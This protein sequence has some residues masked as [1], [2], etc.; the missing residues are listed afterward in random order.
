[1]ASQLGQIAAWNDDPE[2]ASLPVGDKQSVLNNYFDQNLADKEFYQL[3]RGEQDK[4]KRSFIDAQYPQAEP[5]PMGQGP[6]R[7]SPEAALGRQQ[8]A[9]V[10]PQQIEQPGNGDGQQQQPEPGPREMVGQYVQDT[11]ANDPFLSEIDSLV[12]DGFAAPETTGVAG[13][14][15]PEPVQ[16]EQQVMGAS[17]VPT[18]FLERAGQEFKGGIQDVQLDIQGFDI[19]M[20]RAAGMDT[21]AE[22]QG[23]LEARKARGEQAVEETDDGWLKKAALGAVRMSGPMAQG[24][25]EGLILGGITA[26]AGQIGPQVLTPEE[27][28][29]VPLAVAVGAGQ[30]WYRQGF[31]EVYGSMIEKG[32]DPDISSK[33]ATIAAP[34]YAYIEFSQ[35]RKIAP[36]LERVIKRKV[37]DTITKTVTK[38]FAK[39]G[40]DVA[41]ETGEEILQEAV[42]AGGEEVGKVINNASEGTDLQQTPIKEVWSR[43]WETA[44]ATV[45]PMM[46]LLGPKRAV[47]TAKEASARNKFEKEVDNLTFEQR[48]SIGLTDEVLKSDYNIDMKGK[49]TAGEQKKQQEF[50]DQKRQPFTKDLGPEVEA[51]VS[52]EEV[53]TDTAEQLDAELAVL[54]AEAKKL[55]FTGIRQ[56]NIQRN[57]AIEKEGGQDLLD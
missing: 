47:R 1:M 50:L 19:A 53:T 14:P 13:V 34:I 17:A 16:Q 24:T 23:W 29:T 52:A 42:L 39:Y 22:L 26:A 28:V 48:M 44:K 8:L 46:F 36:G 12:S 45:G 31:G 32:V 43:L 57:D 55:G 4:V 25:M 6:L 3:D 10:S 37:T 38:G 5:Q 40:T 35:V 21:D 7:E 18:S 9:P 20:K 2:W 54:D 41:T 15:Q 27:I 30:Y 49:P 11:I 33:V 56:L 51:E